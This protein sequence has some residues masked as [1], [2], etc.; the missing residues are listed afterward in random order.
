MMQGLLD[1]AKSPAGVGLLSAVAGGLAGARRGAPLNTLGAA[2]LAGLTG[3][4]AA[5]AMQE[6]QLARAQAEKV[7]QAIPAMYK[8]KD[9]GSMQFDVQG[10]I[11]SGLFTP[12]QIKSYAEVPN[13]GRAKVARTLEVAGPGGV[14]LGLGGGLGA[15]PARREHQARSH[16]QGKAHGCAPGEIAVHRTVSEAGM[17]AAWRPV[18]R[19]SWARSVWKALRASSRRLRASIRTFWASMTSR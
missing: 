3:Y 7:R 13:Y 4:N 19:A 15:V 10:A 17:R 9:D 16:D 1:F 14:A 5:S 18:R 11:D 8:R 6:K 2:G 12:E